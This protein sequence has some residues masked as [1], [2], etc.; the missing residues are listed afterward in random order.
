[1]AATKVGATRT[2]K[3]SST[4]VSTTKASTANGCAG[5][6]GTTK[7]ST[8]KASVA[9]ASFTPRLRKNPTG[10]PYDTANLF[11]HSPKTTKKD[12]GKRMIKDANGV[13]MEI[14]WSAHEYKKKRVRTPWDNM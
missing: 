1:M 10:M 9:K 7:A 6:N 13:M 5:R 12:L 3:T 11:N 8:K 4:Q 14:T 2:T